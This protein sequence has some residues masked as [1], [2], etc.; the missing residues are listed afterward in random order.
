MLEAIIAENAEEKFHPVIFDRISGSLVRSVALKSEGAAGP[1]G[2]DAADWRRFCSS[3]HGASAALCESIAALARCLC[4]SFFRSFS[5]L[6]FSGLL[7]D[8]LG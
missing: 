1:S 3:F 6:C 7:F 8:C 5:S 4:T 2:A